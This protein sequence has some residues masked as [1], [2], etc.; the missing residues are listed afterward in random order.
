MNDSNV[1]VGFAPEFEAAFATA[2]TDFVQGLDTLARLGVFS[3][4]STTR[5][6]VMPQVT[7]QNNVSA[8]QLG[9]V[10]IRDMEAALLMLSLQLHVLADATGRSPNSVRHLDRATPENSFVWTRGQAQPELLQAMLVVL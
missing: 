9:N 8:A 10:G 5:G 3:A 4:G 7:G 1:L 6:P 2:E